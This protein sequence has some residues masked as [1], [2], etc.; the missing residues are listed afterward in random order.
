[1]IAFSL[2]E[3]LR[4]PRDRERRETRE[5]RQSMRIDGRTR[6]VLLVCGALTV[7]AVVGID[8]GAIP[9]GDGTITALS[10]EHDRCARPKS[11]GSRHSR[12]FDA[13]SLGSRC[14][15]RFR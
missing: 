14:N 7:V 6:A 4:L 8:R 12:A 15:Q 3:C 10:R 9:A 13:N 11:A 1:L 5:R 2:G